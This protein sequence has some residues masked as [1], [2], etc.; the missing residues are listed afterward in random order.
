MK[1][2]VTY[3]LT[4]GCATVLA[5]TLRI[6]EMIRLQDDLRP[7]F[8]SVGITNQP[9]VVDQGATLRGSYREGEPNGFSILAPLLINR[10]DQRDGALPRLS[11]HSNSWVYCS[12]VPV[13]TNA[14]ILVRLEYG[15]EADTNL[16][17][18]I[19][20]VIER[21]R[22]ILCIISMNSAPSARCPW[23]DESDVRRKDELKAMGLRG[24]VLIEVTQQ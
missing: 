19:K 18:K 3:L 12:F 15:P 24:T 21:N 2:I 10:P 16:I 5:V 9:V 4:L 8:L 13:K 17:E 14:S 1:R 22:T 20:A 23:N 6:P 11:S 7:I